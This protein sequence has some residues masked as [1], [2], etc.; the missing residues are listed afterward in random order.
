VLKDAKAGKEEVLASTAGSSSYKWFPGPEQA[1]TWEL[2]A[3]VTDQGG[4]TFT[5]DPLT[6]YVP[7]KPV[8]ILETVGP[9][10]VLSGTVKL[11]S[12]ANVSLDQISYYL[13]SPQSGAKRVIA[14]GKE[15]TSEYSWTP[16]K[17]DAGSW[18][19]QAVGTAAS[20]K[21]IFSEAVPVKVYDG[22]VYGAQ[23]IIEKEKF[24]DLLTFNKT[25]KSMSRNRPL[26]WR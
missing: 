7:D 10:Q 17:K 2:T 18:Q 25:P 13:I 24:L 15:G 20:G 5:S 1:G 8:I 26:S 4:N 14:G 3:R 9:N 19:I 11:K 23:P 16:E 6:V 12:L 21:T 22:P